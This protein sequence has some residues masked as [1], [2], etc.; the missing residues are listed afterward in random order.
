M[1]SLLITTDWQWKILG[2]ARTWR[3]KRD[4]YTLEVTHCPQNAADWQPSALAGSSERDGRV[5]GSLAAVLE[6]V[7]DPSQMILAFDDLSVFA[8]FAMP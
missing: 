5:V 3:A 8:R 7:L 2:F 6:Y 4:S 1:V